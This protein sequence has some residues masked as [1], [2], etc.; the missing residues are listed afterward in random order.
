MVFEGRNPGVL[1]KSLVLFTCL[2]AGI[3]SE[4]LAQESFAQSLSEP[5]ESL[6]GEHAAQEL[7]RALTNEDYNIH[8]GDLRFQSQARLSAAYTD[9]VFLSG[10]DKKDDFI[11]SPEIDLAA[12]LPIGHFN[13]LRLS[14]GLGYEWFAKNHTLNSDVPLVNPDSELAF[15][16]LVGDFRIKVH[17]KFTYQQTL[18]FDEQVANQVRFYNFNDV[19]RF[20][21]FNN[22]AGTTIDWD[23]NK[24]I[25]TGSYDHENFISTTERF[26]YLNRASELFGL[27]GNYL[28]GDR[29]KTGLEGVGSYN[30]FDTE[31]I[32][33][34]NWRGRVGPFAAV[35]LPKGIVLR[36]GG[37]YEL[38]RFDSTAGPGNNYSDYYLYGRLSQETKW[39]THSIGA[40]HETLP[41]DNANNLRTTYVRYSISTDV[42]R[43]TTIEGYG[44]VNFSREFGG[45]F[46]EKY[47]NYVAGCVL[48]YQ[49]HKYW[50]AGLAYEFFYKDSEF[51]DRTF[52]RNLVSVDLAFKF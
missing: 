30:N 26:E 19:A 52:H 44:S 47:D 50:R 21:R 46:E 10:T 25:L 5:R 3:S 11:I 16:L 36:A 18:A 7:R 40:G 15:Y 29:T 41:G 32:L 9:N 34:D 39:F 1:T 28:L 49:F 20:D 4:A 38:A 8:V 24:V 22:F 23:L 12:L 45:G 48:G 35:K 51:S 17:D 33:N 13:S 43:N 14:V 31:T 37:G 27:T 2:W 42:V 6:A